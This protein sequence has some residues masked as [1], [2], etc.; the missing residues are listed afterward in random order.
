MPN[1]TSHERI[2][3]TLTKYGV[4]SDGPVIPAK[5]LDSLTLRTEKGGTGREGSGLGLA[6]VCRDCGPDC[7]TAHPSI[8]QNRQVFRV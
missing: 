2:E 6:T 4:S 3:V 7:G 5:T 8:A 1:G